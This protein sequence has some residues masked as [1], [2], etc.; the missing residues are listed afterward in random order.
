[1]SDDNVF[2][3]RR[4][5]IC[6]GHVFRRERE[7]RLVARESDGWQFMCG[8]TDHVGPDGKP[9]GRRIHVGHLLNFDP[10]LNHLADLPPEWEAERKDADS[11]WIRTKRGIR[12]T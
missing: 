9:D 10:S 8:G 3:N 4:L 2:H 6:C 12:P 7:V 5:V 11:E 1:M